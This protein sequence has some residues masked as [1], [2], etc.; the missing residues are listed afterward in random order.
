MKITILPP[1]LLIQ[2]RPFPQY[3]R[4]CRNTNNV[5]ETVASKTLKH[6]LKDIYIYIYIYN[7]NG[8]YCLTSRT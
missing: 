2:P 3:I 5:L 1:P 8:V 7:K 4:H 6:N